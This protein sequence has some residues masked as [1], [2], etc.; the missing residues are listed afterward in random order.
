MKRLAALLACLTLLAAAQ[1]AA[2][3]DM[4]SPDGAVV[5]TIAGNIAIANRGAFDPKR[6]GFLK[7]HER[8]FDKAAAFDRAM[9]EAL[10]THSATIQFDGWGAAPITFSGPRLKDVLAAVG[11]TGRQITTLALDGFGT[12]ISR[13][14]IDAFD[15]IQATRT[16][17]KPLGIGQRGPLWLVFDPPGDRAATTEEEGRWPWAIFFIQ[18]E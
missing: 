11:W 8:K 17:G 9:L 18:A 5:M 6:D 10:G 1:T 16:N 7:Y 13:A 12:K 14:D 4:K 3:A 2:A 15:W